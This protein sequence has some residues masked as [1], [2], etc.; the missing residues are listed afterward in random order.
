MLSGDPREA[1]ALSG[2][3][4]A[5][6]CGSSDRVAGAGPAAF[7][8][9]NVPVAVLTLVA[10]F[11]LDVREAST[12]SRDS[13]ALDYIMASERVAFTS[14]ASFRRLIAERVTIV[15]V[16]A[17]FAASTGGVIDALETLPGNAVAVHDSVRVD[18][19]VA[20]TP[21][22]LAKPARVT[23]PTVHAEFALVTD[24]TGRAA[25]TLDQT[26][27]GDSAGYVARA[28]A[29]YASVVVSVLIVTDHTDFAVVSGC[30][31]QTFAHACF[32]V[33]L[34]SVSVALAWHAG[35]VFSAVCRLAGVPRRAGGSE[36]VEVARN[37]AVFDPI[38]RGAG[39]SKLG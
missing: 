24:V 22:A 8:A 10:V 18:V 30:V 17:P 23:E 36:A 39:A 21:L 20:S 34:R 33:A 13:V 19:T 35:G 7:P 15:S 6:S 31:V 26:V 27:R 29:R 14:S 5:F 9:V 4:V 32:W 38:R 2:I 1:V 37:V 28:R 12:L 3:D 25:E 11:S 16:E